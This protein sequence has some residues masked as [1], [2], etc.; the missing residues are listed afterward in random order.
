MRQRQRRRPARSPCVLEHGARAAAAAAH[1]GERLE[2]ALVTPGAARSASARAAKRFTGWP[3]GLRPA[4]ARISSGI[5]HA[6]RSSRQRCA[7]PVTARK[8]LAARM[9]ACASRRWPAASAARGSC[10]GCSPSWPRAASRRRHRHRQHRRRHHAVRPAGVP[11]PRHG[12]VHPR[13]RHPRGAGLGP[14]DETFAVKEE[15][16]AYGVE[17]Q[18]FGLGDRDI[19]THIVRT[20][21]LAAGLPALR[22]DRG[23]VRSAGSR[24]SGCCR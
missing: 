6:S 5:A 15:L 10:A 8:L 2:R 4:A 13:R 3:H 17:P 23:A 19:A 14:A 24:A 12:H 11:R 7:A 16:A 18:W 1:V 21:M 20:Q 22:R 9:T